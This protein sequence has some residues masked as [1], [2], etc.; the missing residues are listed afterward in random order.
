MVHRNTVF[1]R[2]EAKLAR[3][4]SHFQR[5]TSLPSTPSVNFPEYKA[6]YTTGCK[7]VF[8]PVIMTRCQGALT[9]KA[10]TNRA[11]SFTFSQQLA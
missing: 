10:G 6:N 1:I 8:A 7:K 5:E 11:E 9:T 3:N 4:T 2:E